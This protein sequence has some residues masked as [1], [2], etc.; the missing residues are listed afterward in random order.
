[1]TMRIRYNDPTNNGEE[2]WNGDI[3]FDELLEDFI[4]AVEKKGVYPC[5]IIIQNLD[6]YYDEDEED[7][8]DREEMWSAKE[9]LEYIERIGY[10]GGI[11]S[12]YLGET[13]EE[14][15]KLL[16]RFKHSPKI[17]EYLLELG[18]EY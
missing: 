5:D 14:S 3:F 8:D 4:E 18:Y 9:M 1:M 13:P 17:K 7:E 12:I 15:R 10:E 16:N 2:Y 11:D 6:G